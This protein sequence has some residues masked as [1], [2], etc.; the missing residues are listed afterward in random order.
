MTQIYKKITIYYRQVNSI[1]ICRSYTC[2]YHSD[3]DICRA[4][5][6]ICR[7]NVLIVLLATFAI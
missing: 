1:C 4:D 7:A 6:R 5:I 2:I 3:I